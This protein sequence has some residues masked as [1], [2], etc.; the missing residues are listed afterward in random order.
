MIADGHVIKRDTK[1]VTL[2]AAGVPHDR[3]EQTRA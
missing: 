3:R 2:N 1:P